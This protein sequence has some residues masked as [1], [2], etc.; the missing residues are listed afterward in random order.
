MFLMSFLISL[1]QQSAESEKMLLWPGLA[2]TSQVPHGAKFS[3]TSCT[4][5]LVKSEGGTKGHLRSL[6]AP[7]VCACVFLSSLID[8]G[9]Q[10]EDTFSNRIG[11]QVSKCVGGILCR[12]P[13][14]EGRCGEGGGGEAQGNAELLH[15]NAQSLGSHL[16]ENTEAC[17]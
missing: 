15:H 5:F 1:H 10:L 17:Q 6:P 7:I 2:L 9:P 16:D 12:F 8:A 3:A 13:S 14:F 11:P 4:P